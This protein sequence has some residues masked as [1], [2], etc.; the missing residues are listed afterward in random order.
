MVGAG[1]VGCATA[2]ALEALGWSVCLQ[3]P[4]SLG[5]QPDPNWDL[6]VFTISPGNERLLDILGVW[7]HLD[8]ARLS[9]VYKMEVAGDGGR[10]SLEFD[11]MAAGVSH[12][13][14]VVEGGRLQAA[15]EAR[16]HARGGV[17]VE[18]GEIADLTWSHDK[19]VSKLRDG[20][21]ITGKLVCGADG[22]DSQVRTRAGIALRQRGY[23][24]QGV[25]ANFRAQ[26]AHRGRAFQWFRPDGVLAL[27]PLPGHLLSMVW[28]TDD[29]HARELCAHDPGQL[30]A[31]VA[32]ASQGVLGELEALSPARAFPLRYGRA[33]PIVGHRVVLLGD[34]AHCVHPLAGQ[35]VNLGLRDVSDLGDYLKEHRYDADV[36]ASGRLGG[37][38]NRRRS[39]ILAVMALT[40]GLHR[41][42]AGTHPILRRMRTDGMRAVNELSMLK[43]ALI[44]HAMS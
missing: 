27:L 29:A 26:K 17:R 16:L 25:V 39:D 8:A 34:A 22:A 44:Q 11:A 21:A 20:R 36:A 4:H 35:G 19:V 23:G 28:S 38:E 7:Q 30:A 24:Q 37:F 41:L 32:A 31:Q 13:A 5:A 1:Y 40:D 6:R 15:M 9:P 10:G 18:V 43:R 14:T 33:D 42:F 12:L 2:L 3:S